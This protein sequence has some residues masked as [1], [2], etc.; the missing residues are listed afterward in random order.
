M[1]HREYLREVRRLAEAAAAA[2]AA[3]AARRPAGSDR[4]QVE[5][6]A[7]IDSFVRWGRAAAVFTGGEQKTENPP[8]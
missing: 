3:A 2:A 1:T 7:P 6:L 8:F 4:R 5:D